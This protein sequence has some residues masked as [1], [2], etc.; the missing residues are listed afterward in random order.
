MEKVNNSIKAYTQ[1][2][3][4][5]IIWGIILL[6]TNA[7]TTFDLWDALKKVPQAISMYVLIGLVFTKWIWRWKIFYP[8]LIKLPNIQGTWR[9][10]IKSDWVDTKTGQRVDSVPAILVIRQSYLSIKCTLMT[11]ESTSYSTTAD[12]NL[13]SGGDDLCLSYNY[14]NR[15]RVTVRDRSEMHDGASTLK[16][17]R[18]PKSLEGE[19]W[20]SRK[21]RGE[22]VL[23]FQSKKL[24][25]KFS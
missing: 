8:W 1:I 4:F 22:V 5:L 23:H 16:I 15:P 7:L 24:A 19:Y 10:E 17:I 21:T 20:T 12:I 14:T 13:I 11:A 18:H 6:S 2:F 3:V 9:G 25:E